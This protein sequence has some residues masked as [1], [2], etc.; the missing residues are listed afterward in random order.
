MWR[1]NSA[2]AHLGP[3]PCPFLCVAG[4][5]SEVK[6]WERTQSKKNYLWQLHQKTKEIALDTW[7]CCFY[8]LVEWMFKCNTE[9]WRKV[10]ITLHRWRA[11][12]RVRHRRRGSVDGGASTRMRGTW[13]KEGENV[14][15]Y[16]WKHN[17]IHPS[18]CSQVLYPSS[19]PV[20]LDHAWAREQSNCFWS[21]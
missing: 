12:W 7:S 21:G 15:T 9:I 3:I 5:D 13:G 18:L 8:L 14:G 10:L 6:K 11:H 1:K 2:S 20:K 4:G 17:L 16:H 19:L